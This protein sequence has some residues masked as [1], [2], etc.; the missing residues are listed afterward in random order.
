MDS[1][2]GKVL[3]GETAIS[4]IFR[5]ELVGG[6]EAGGVRGPRCLSGEGR[7]DVREIKGG[8]VRGRVEMGWEVAVV[9]AGGLGR[10]MGVRIVTGCVGWDG[11]IIGWRRIY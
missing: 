4:P 10:E 9:N 8:G 5:G 3:R 11:T 2:S 1:G 6:M 7:V